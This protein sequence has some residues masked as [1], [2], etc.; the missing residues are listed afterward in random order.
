MCLADKEYEQGYGVN[1]Q[2]R[3]EQQTTIL[4][5]RRTK[6]KYPNKVEIENI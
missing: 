1:A 5:Y 4:F 3:H 2:F 6:K